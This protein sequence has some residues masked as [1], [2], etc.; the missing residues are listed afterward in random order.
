MSGRYK[1]RRRRLRTHAS[2]RGGG[3]TS[4]SQSGSSP[5]FSSRSECAFENAR[6]SGR[7]RV[8]RI[9]RA[10]F[11]SQIARGFRRRVRFERGGDARAAATPAAATPSGSFFA[12]AR[13]A[14]VDEQPMVT[15]RWVPFFW[16]VPRHERVPRQSSSSRIRNR[17]RASQPRPAR[18]TR[19]ETPTQRFVFVSSRLRRRRSFRS[20]AAFARARSDSRPRA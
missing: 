17:P 5:C 15:R 8:V 2:M 7:S 16:W 9:E 12:G 14:S 13:R 10:R 20:A 18:P 4:R 3:R 6:R 1:K 11:L 19:P